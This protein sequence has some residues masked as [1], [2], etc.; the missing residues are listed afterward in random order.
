[1]RDD[2]P[3]FAWG[4]LKAAREDFAFAQE[5]FASHGMEHFSVFEHTYNSSLA[6]HY[7][8][9]VWAASN[10]YLASGEGI[11]AQ[12]ARRWAEQLMACQET[13]DRAPLSGFF[14]RD[15]QKKSIVHFCHQSREQQFM[16]AFELLCRTQPDSPDR[17]K[18]ER[19][20]LLYGGYLKALRRYT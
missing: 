5:R 9:M 3:D 14:Y 10:L 4:S 7:A 19:A 11:Y 15:E 16:Q 12:D 20:M 1:M 8:V 13:G 17:P 18:W 6:Q 2:D